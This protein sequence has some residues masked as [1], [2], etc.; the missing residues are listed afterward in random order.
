MLVSC[1][2]FSARS[3]AARSSID[4]SHWNLTLPTG[5]KDHPDVISTA[6]LMA[7]YSSQYFYAGADGG[8]IF[9]CPVTGV[10]TK[11]TRYPRTELRET[12]RDGALLNWHVS[13]GTARLEATLAVLQVPG[14]GRLTVGQIH[15]NASDIKSE[16]LIK[17]VYEYSRVTQSGDLVAQIRS[18][19]ADSTN[20]NYFVAKGLKLGERFSYR[21]ELNPDRTLKVDVDGNEAWSGKIEKEW[22]SQGLYFKAGAYLQDNQG[23]ST[24]GGRVEFYRL[25]PSH[26]TAD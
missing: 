5:T 17:L 9:W 11:G 19:P 22:E 8:L 2:S 10:T 24:D 25:A 16:P 13:D 21:I 18:F 20:A 4:L 6:Q 14:T 26:D 15:D 7:G 12:T 1:C 23:S 3:A